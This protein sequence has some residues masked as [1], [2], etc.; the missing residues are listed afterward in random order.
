MKLFWYSDAVTDLEK[1]YDYYFPLSSNYAATLYNTILDDAEI[2]QTHPYIAPKEQ[3]LEDLK[4]EYRS[5]VVAKGKYKLIY[6]IENDTVLIVQIFA[7][8]QS[9]DKIKNI[10]VIR[11]KNTN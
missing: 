11:N 7:C 1:I 5:L 4:E 10:T 8:Q 3:L 2:L 6:Y 9:P